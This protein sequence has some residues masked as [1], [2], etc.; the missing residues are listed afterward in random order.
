MQVRAGHTAG[1]ADAADDLAALDR[2]THRDERAAQVKIDGH[3][4]LTVMHVH[5]DAA[6]EE[7]PDERYDAAVRGPHRGPF[8]AGEI[9]T[10]MPA[11]PHAVHL[12][13]GAEEARDARGAGT[14]ERRFPQL[15][16]V[17]RS[18]EHTSELQ[19]RLHLVCRL[20][21]EKKKKKN[22]NTRSQYEL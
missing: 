10:R 22:K 5:R 1:R 19:S 4:T 9:E 14:K 7:I 6:V 20:L 18:E 13:S 21:L 2:I 12:T 3:Q 16:Y 17:V 15:G 11:A 8:A